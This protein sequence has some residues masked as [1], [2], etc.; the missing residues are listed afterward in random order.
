MSV[1]NL[2]AVGVACEQFIMTVTSLNDFGGFGWPVDSY[3]YGFTIPQVSKCII[4]RYLSSFLRFD[5]SLIFFFLYF[6][7]SI[8]HR[9]VAKNK[10]SLG[11]LTTS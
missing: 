8:I 10:E 5:S 6:A 9:R 2:P 7:F 11:T 3:K 1:V 4:C